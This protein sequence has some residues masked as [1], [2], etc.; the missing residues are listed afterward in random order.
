MKVFQYMS[1][2]IP[3]GDGYPFIRQKYLFSIN[4]SIRGTKMH[5]NTVILQ[6]TA[7][8]FLML[9]WGRDCC[10]YILTIPLV[11]LLM[12]VGSAAPKGSVSQMSGVW[13]RS[14]KYQGSLDFSSK[15][16]RIIG[17]SLRVQN[18]GLLLKQLKIGL[19]VYYVLKNFPLGRDPPSCTKISYVPYFSTLP[20]LPM[21]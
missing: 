21:V 14:V 8:C 12:T 10:L 15:I 17:F 7:S 16:S 3:L 4:F 19:F 1:T 9:F 13:D 6:F 18:R 20:P 2:K 5:E 11:H